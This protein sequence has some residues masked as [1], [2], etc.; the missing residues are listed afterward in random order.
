VKNNDFDFIKKKFDTCENELPCSLETKMLADKLVTVKRNKFIEFKPRKN[1]K[2]L[3]SA[4][5]CFIV[6]IGLVFAA[7]AGN[8]FGSNKVTE[9]KDYNQINDRL[10]S[11]EKVG[12]PDQLGAGNFYSQMYQEEDGV[13]QPDEIKTDGKYIYYGFNKLYR[14]SE[15]VRNVYIFSAEDSSSDPVAVIYNVVPKEMSLC[16]LFLYENRLIVCAESDNY[17]TFIKIYDVTDPTNPVLFSEFEQQGEYGKAYMLDNVLYV[18]SG[19][20]VTPYTDGSRVPTIV[21]NGKSLQLDAKDIVCFDNAAF[22]QFAVINEMDVKEGKLLNPKAVLGGSADVYCTKEYVYVNEY[23]KGEDYDE[24]E[25]AVES[26]VKMSLDEHKFSYAKDKEINSYMSAGV[27]IGKGSSYHSVLYKTGDYILSIGRSYTGVSKDEI[28][29]FDKDFKYL[30]CLV[31]DATYLD[32]DKGHLAI[33]DDGKL[34]AVSACFED[35]GEGA[36]TFK[37]EDGKLVLAEEYVNENSNH[38]YQGRCLIIGDYLYSFDHNH[39]E[40]D[41]ERPELFVY[42]CR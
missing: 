35:A 10:E 21:N 42:N 26:A 30:D 12:Y 19:Y 8:L 22:A 31:P 36:V 40:Q 9:F 32:I 23:I 11:L 16:G 13:E 38:M 34:F 41:D 25:R 3:L 2:P 37:I 33:C 5:A 17:T 4:A 24:P 20:K 18:A 29:L 15:N 6:V 14:E 28:L 1:Y 27:D 39:D 7:T